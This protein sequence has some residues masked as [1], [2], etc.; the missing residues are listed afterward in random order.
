M[1][2]VGVPPQGFLV[3]FAITWCVAVGYVA[4][5]LAALARIKRLERP[6][7]RLG[8]REIFSQSLMF[9]A[10]G[11]LIGARHTPLN[12]P[13]ATRLV[14]TARALFVVAL[15]LILFVFWQAFQLAGTP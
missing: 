7:E 15:P 9:E 12:D 1:K 8:L 6:G 10:L 4:V 2:F 13:L 11:V 14:W 5:L 3:L